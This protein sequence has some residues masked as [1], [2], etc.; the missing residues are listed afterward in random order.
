MALQGSY[1]RALKNFLFF[2]LPT[3]QF[4]LFVNLYTIYFFCVYTCRL[5]YPCSEVA[6]CDVIK[7]QISDYV[8]VDLGWRYLTKADIFKKKGILV[9]IFTKQ[10]IKIQFFT[11]QNVHHMVGDHLQ[12]FLSCM[13]TRAS[14]P[15]N[16]LLFVVCHKLRNISVN[17]DTNEHYIKHNCDLQG[18]PQ[19]HIVIKNATYTS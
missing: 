3:F 10:C 4:Y 17:K 9:C 5:K 16:S 14:S 19:N 18:F 2:S 15:I 6:Y 1:H 8:I 11:Q 7:H 13:E 12:T